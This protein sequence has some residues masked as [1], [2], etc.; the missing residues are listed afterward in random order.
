MTQKIQKHGVKSIL[1][2]AIPTPPVEVAGQNVKSQL[3][4]MSTSVVFYSF[5]LIAYS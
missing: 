3:D 1:L 2:R 4:N 5:E